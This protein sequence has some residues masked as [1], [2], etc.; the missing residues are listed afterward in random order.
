MFC[1]LGIYEVIVDELDPSGSEQDILHYK[2]ALR[3][4]TLQD[5]CLVHNTDLLLIVD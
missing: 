2:S 3:Q 1:F 5:V 4:C